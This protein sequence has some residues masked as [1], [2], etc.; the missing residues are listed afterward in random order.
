MEN[1]NHSYGSLIAL[2]GSPDAVSTQLRLLPASSQLL[3]LP[4]LESYMG[5]ASDGPV[6]ARSLIKQ[7][8]DAAQKRHEAAVQFLKD[9]SPTNKRLVFLNGGTAGAVSHCITAIS[10]NQTAGD[11]HQAELMFRNIALEGLRG[12]DREDKQSDQ[13]TLWM[14]GREQTSGDSIL[15]SEEPEDPITKAMRAADLLYKETDSLQP[16]DC[17]IR[18]RP[19][20]L[21]LP[22]YGYSDGMG[23]PS[24]FFVF[25]TAPHEE[26]QVFDAD[27]KEPGDHHGMADEEFAKIC[28]IKIQPGTS[29]DN[30]PVHERAASCAGESYSHRIAE[31]RSS[32]RRSDAFLSPPPTPDGVVYGEARVVQMRASKTRVTLRETRSLDDLELEQT[33]SRRADFDVVSVA[34]QAAPLADNSEAKSRHLSIT[35]K[36]SSANTLLHLPQARFVKAHTTTIRRSPTFVRRLPKPARDSY[37]HRGTD[38]AEFQEERHE[39]DEPFQ[40]VLPVVEDLVIHM[41]DQTPDAILGMVVQYFKAGAFPVVPF[42]ASLQTAP[43]DSCPSTPRTA[44]LF[45]LEDVDVGLS[46]VIEHP[47][48]EEIG[49][50]DPFAARGRDVRASSLALQ[51]PSPPPPANVPPDSR[52]P[53]VIAPISPPLQRE[54]EFRFHDFST[55]GRPNAVATQNAL[56]SVLEVYFPPT[57]TGCVHHSNFPMFR[58]IGSLW[59]PIF[60]DKEVCD[61]DGDENAPDMILAMG[62]QKGVK[63]GFLTT[64]TGQVEKLGAKSSGMSR[65]GRLDLRYLIANAMQSL[66]AQPLSHQAQDNRFDDHYLLAGLI[67]PHL[68]TYLAANYGTRFLLLDYPAEHLATVLALQK[69]VGMAV[70]KVAGI[71]DSEATSPSPSGISSPISSRHGSHSADPYGNADTNGLDSFN[72]PGSPFPDERTKTSLAHRRSCSFSEA[73]YLL[74]SSATESEISVFIATILKD[75]T[76]IDPFYMPEVSIPPPARPGT[77]KSS[78]KSTATAGAGLPTLMS[79]FTLQGP[80]ASPAYT[81]T[82]VFGPPANLPVSPPYT[83]DGDGGSGRSTPRVVTAPGAAAAAYN[84]P[85]PPPPAPRSPS[86]A[87]SAASSRSRGPAAGPGARA[88]SLTRRRLGKLGNEGGP[89]DG[90]SMYAV[91]VVE[92]GEFYDEEEKRLMPLYMRQSELRKGNSRKALKWLGLA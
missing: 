8:H 83:N 50:Y 70:F 25:G 23:E 9:A 71:I 75:L 18:T 11:I 76:D 37:V 88:R 81:H 85:F 30:P 15:E 78:S 7:V 58:D 59:R 2:E 48:A 49:E 56:R 5:E 4:N 73:N 64:L 26:T 72:L 33:R 40:P 29:E 90:A 51:P 42:P 82:A 1:R 63:R 92:D 34:E 32:T 67:I 13:A 24:P 60:G 52:Q 41:T 84:F 62:R 46:P 36:P 44:D 74:T 31:A 39:L 66:A 19:R 86:P 77:A 69:L 43:T 87:P 14:L 21:S 10:E 53:P 28:A 12:L 16:I 27:D 65:S 61:G 68:E 6:K 55:V 57:D 20:S 22:M 17:Y 3:V 38:A 47:G 35:D 45:D 54:K 89:D 80:N 79:K 91:S